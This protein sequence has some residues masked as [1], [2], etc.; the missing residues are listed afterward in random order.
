MAWLRSRWPSDTMAT[1]SPSKGTS[2]S[3]VSRELIPTIACAG[4]LYGSI[5]YVHDG[6]ARHHPDRE[7]HWWCGPCMAGGYR[8]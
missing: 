3:R 2:A 5:H 8:S 1:G 4:L 7:V 6:R